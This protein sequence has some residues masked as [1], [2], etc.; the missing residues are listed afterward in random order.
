M[1]DP[2]QPQTMGGRV[3]GDGS[4]ATQTGDFTVSRTAAGRYSIF[5]P[6]SFRLTGF[7]ST[8]INGA[9]AYTQIGTMND[10][11]VDLVV[12]STTTPATPIDSA[13]TFTAT[14]MTP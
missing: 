13:F 12:A 4:V 11:Q 3:G 5:F 7:G 14:G 1:R 9:V 2:R 10:H 6:V 8:A